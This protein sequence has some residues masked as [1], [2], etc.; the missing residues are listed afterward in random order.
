MNREIK[1]SREVEKYLRGTE[2]SLSLLVGY[3]NKG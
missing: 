2:I 1:G 3:I